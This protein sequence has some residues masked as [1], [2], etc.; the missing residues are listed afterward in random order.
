[1]LILETDFPDSLI[2][3]VKS[4]FRQLDQVIRKGIP[5]ERSREED[6]TKQNAH[7]IEQVCGR[8]R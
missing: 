3:R 5:H 6:E 7:L 4:L 8:Q 2:E 1:M